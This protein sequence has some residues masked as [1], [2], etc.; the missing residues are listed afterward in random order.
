MIKA[1][2]ARSILDFGKKKDF[3]EQVSLLKTQL[4]SAVHRA[5]DKGMSAAYV[6]VPLT[7]DNYILTGFIKALKKLG[8]STR[9]DRKDAY[10]DDYQVIKRVPSVTLTVWF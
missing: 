4:D 7:L 1:S 3:S 6:E 2:E 10:T 5:L 8:Y 9:I